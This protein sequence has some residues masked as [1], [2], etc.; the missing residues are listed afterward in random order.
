MA[1]FFDIVLCPPTEPLRPPS[2]PLGPM[3]HPP[4]RP[5]KATHLTRD[6]RRDIQLLH[7]IGWSYSQI[8]RQTKATLNQIRTTIVKATPRKRSGRPPLL[9]QSQVEELVE[10]VCASSTN[11]RMSYQKLAEVMD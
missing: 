11:R 9:T 3:P 2:E 7:S 5:P 4:I 8:H 10:F 1:S 6:Q